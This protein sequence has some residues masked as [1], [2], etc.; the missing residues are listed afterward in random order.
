MLVLPTVSRYW[1]K[2]DVIKRSFIFQGL[3]DLL[4]TKKTSALLSAF[5]DFYPPT[6]LIFKIIFHPQEIIQAYPKYFRFYGKKET[7]FLDDKK[8]HISLSLKFRSMPYLHK[9]LEAFLEFPHYVYC[10]DVQDGQIKLILSFIF[11]HIEKLG[12]MLALMCM[13]VNAN[14]REHTYSGQERRSEHLPHERDSKKGS[15]ER[16]GIQIGLLH[17]LLSKIKILRTL[18]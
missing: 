2:C 3:F 9:T 16:P 8:L 18:E 12:N 4:A 15:V 6:D 11:F 10:V 14:Q 1:G 13:Q 7:L 5:Y 17:A